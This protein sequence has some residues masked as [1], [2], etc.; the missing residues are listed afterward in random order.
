[1]NNKSSSIKKLLIGGLTAAMVLGGTTSAFAS[2]HKGE[3]HRGNGKSKQ[4]QKSKQQK[5]AKSKPKFKADFADIKG[6]DVEW[7]NRHI[8]S[9]ASLQVFEGYE[10][11]TFQPRKAV[12]RLETIAAA[13]RLMGL[14]DQAESEKEMKAQL[15]FRDADKLTK[16]YPWAVGYV[17][18]AL[19]NDLFLENETAIQPEASADRLWATTLLV[20]AMKLDKEAKEKMNTKLDFKDADQIPAGAV[21]YVAVAVEKGIIQGYENGKFMP[22]KPV[23]RAELAALLDRTGDQMPD[24]GHTLKAGTVVSAV[25]NN[26]LIIQQGKDSVQL[27]LDP[28]V[29]VFKNGVKVNVSSIQ[30]GDYVKVRMYNNLGIFVD[31]IRSGEVNS[32]KVRGGFEKFGVDNRGKISSI[33]ISENVNGQTKSVTYPVNDDVRLIGDTSKL[34]LTDPKTQVELVGSN[35]QVDVIQVIQN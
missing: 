28:D 1:M 6:G 8:A 24:V 34:V 22:N 32:L 33:T 10:D 25:S 17:S 11:G 5:P 35:Y 12:T 31:I 16:K 2:D 18:V 29:F 30:A 4:E 19:A 20:K 7:A 23:T 26:K 15:N 3:D 21:G 9:L 14:R 13:V 27:T